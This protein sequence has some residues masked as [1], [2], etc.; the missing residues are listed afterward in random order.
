MST[1]GADPAASADA[2]AK[3]VEAV[4]DRALRE[5]ERTADVA[6]LEAVRTRYL[7]RRDG[8]LT[9]FR[10]QL[11]SLEPQARVAFGQ[12]VNSLVER[13]QT[14][15][16]E[17]RTALEN[18]ARRDELAAEALD[19]SRPAPSLSRGRLHPVTLAER[20][21]RRIFA[22]LGYQAVAGPEIEYDRF[23]FTLVNMPPGHPARD[24]QDTFFIDDRRLLRTQTTAVQIRTMMERGAPMRVI[25]PGK[26]YRR[27]HDATHSP[28][29]FQVEGICI[30]EGIAL[31]D[32]KG[33]LEYFVR[34]LFGPERAIRMRPHH[35][36][37]TEPSLEIEVSCMMCGGA[38]CGLCKTT[39]WI[40]VL[41][42]GMIHPQVLRNGGIDPERYT[43]F[44][45]GVGID[46][47]AMLA[48]HVP[49]IRLLFENDVRFLRSS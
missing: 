29:F 49:D 24:T 27:D 48:Y 43:G 13:V 12:V 47:I 28:M 38:G 18:Q 7:G 32:L 8:E 1:A 21:I 33:T 36:P 30:D 19:L 42:C 44:A 46:R 26:V 25:V 11:G 6:Q 41:G 15:M 17:Q 20:E 14:A 10:R 4:A 22:H 34:S 31:S 45:F 16:T 35:F 37:Y 2:R 40:E 9:I 23:N 39:G 3:D 5:I